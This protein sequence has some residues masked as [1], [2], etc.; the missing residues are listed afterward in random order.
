MSRTSTRGAAFSFVPLLLLKAYTEAGKRIGTQR[1]RETEESFISVA[2]FLCVRPI[3]FAD[4]GLSV[5]SPWLVACR[6]PRSESVRRGHAR[7]WL[8]KT[9][10][11]EPSSHDALH[12]L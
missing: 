10:R 3:L 7:T 8:A 12:L 11:S 2:L 5:Y 4:S 6:T 9:E 1:N